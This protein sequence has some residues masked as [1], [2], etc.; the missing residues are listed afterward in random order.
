[1]N[2]YE[3]AVL[4]HFPSPNCMWQFYVWFFKTASGHYQAY[5]TIFLLPFLGCYYF[6]RHYSTILLL[7]RKKTQINDTIVQLKLLICVESSF[8]LLLIIIII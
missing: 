2:K 3:L 4:M 5:L 6:M 7:V 8:T 1:M